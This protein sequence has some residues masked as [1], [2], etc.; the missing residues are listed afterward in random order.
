[1]NLEGNVDKIMSA[2]P[3]LEHLDVSN[4][5]I[6]GT[7]PS[8]SAMS[9]LRF[10]QVRDNQQMAGSIP[11]EIGN[12]KALVRFIENKSSNSD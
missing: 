7:I 9:N 1:M 4:T 6:G 11:I 3:N 5:E 12:W 10:F 2:M 8:D